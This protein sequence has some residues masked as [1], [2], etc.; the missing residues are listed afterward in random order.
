MVSALLL[1][2]L[3]FIK[4]FVLPIMNNLE[5]FNEICILIASYHLLVFTNYVN[6]IDLQY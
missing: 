4:P 5:V 2:Y 1:I 6:D 3:L